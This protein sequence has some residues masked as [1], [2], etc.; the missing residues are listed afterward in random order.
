MNYT[1]IMMSHVVIFS[2]AMKDKGQQKKPNTCGITLT[3]K[4]GVGKSSLINSFLPVST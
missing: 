3:G 1:I 4:L 2:V